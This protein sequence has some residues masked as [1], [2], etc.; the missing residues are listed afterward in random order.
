MP[1][2][3]ATIIINNYNYARFLRESIDSALA[4]DYANT[5]VI[6]VDDGS[7]DGSR[8]IIASYGDRVIPILKTNG[9]Q[10]STYNAGFARSTGDFVC[11]LDSDDTLHT[12]AMRVVAE[13]FADERVVQ[14]QWPCVVTDADGRPTGEVSTKRTPPE[15]D[16]AEQVIRD[17]PL[18]DFD[19]HTGRAYRRS[20]LSRVLPM[21]EPPYRNGADVYLVTVAPALGLVRNASRPLGTYRAHGDNN[22]R[23]RTL[24]DNR[25]HN[26]VRR[27]EA[28]CEALDRALRLTGR[29]ADIERWRQRNF[30][31]IWPTRL[32]RARADLIELVAR[33]SAF[34]FIDGNELGGAENLPERTTIPFLARDGQYFGTPA[35]DATAIS[36]L[37]RLR[38]AGA[39]HLALWWTQFWWLDTFSGFFEYVRKR[40]VPVLDAEH[41]IVFKLKD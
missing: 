14:V 28:N 34:I 3:R 26:Y 2:P 22:F 24:D 36:E 37:E 21:P 1:E 33:G 13:G 10:G 5:E 20:M 6:V 25:L 17:G 30:N 11:F 40:F 8:D 23:G 4:Q 16:F 27:F 9:G 41:L 12:D 19:F 31:Y 29:A 38:A 18:Y 35:D 7:I 15:G 39:S 32:L